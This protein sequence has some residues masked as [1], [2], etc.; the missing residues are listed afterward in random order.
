MFLRFS[1]S[2]SS[3]SFRSLSSKVPMPLVKELRE[4]TG[5]PLMDCRNALREGDL[6][7]DGAIEWL[8]K[9]GLA[10]A[11]KK[12]GRDASE[13]LV[14]AV[15]SDCRTTAVLVE[16][17]SETDFVAR[18]EKFQALLNGVAQSAL[19]SPTIAPTGQSG[20]LVNMK[21]HIPALLS[22]PFV[23]GEEKI[24]VEEMVKESVGTLQENLVVGRTCKLV[25]NDPLG[26]LEG[27]G[28]LGAYVHG[29][30]QPGSSSGKAGAIVALT[31]G[32]DKSNNEDLSEVARKIAMHIVAARPLYLSRD[33]VPSSVL[34]KE[35]EI[36][37]EELLKQ[38]KPEKMLE[39]IVPG[40]LEKFYKE[41]CL[42]DQEYLL[43][44]DKMKVSE[45]VEKEGGGI[46]IAAFVRLE[47]GEGQ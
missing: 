21:E 46:K 16:V 34:E 5:A 28:A 23:E 41:T 25:V 27:A 10:A 47:T 3:T 35:K 45:V 36:I 11:A 6:N 20:D 31:H 2:L 42:V 22:A 1:H 37:A 29:P 43:S 24:S 12:A 15:I 39:K 8:R 44:G 33:T 9:N 26:P 14:S 17:N 19:A 32:G 4:R 7:L 18:N 30:I 13:G 38:G 40:K